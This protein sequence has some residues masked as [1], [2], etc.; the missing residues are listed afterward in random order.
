MRIRCIYNLLIYEIR[1]NLRNTSDRDIL[2]RV[3]TC[4]YSNYLWRANGR[5]RPSYAFVVEAQQK[6]TISAGSGDVGP[7]TFERLYSSEV[8]YVR[9]GRKALTEKPKYHV[10]KP[11]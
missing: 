2:K 10:G 6:F 8:D 1:N 4:S 11:P 7:P 9:G 3:D 5:R